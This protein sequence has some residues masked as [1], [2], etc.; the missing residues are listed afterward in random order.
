MCEEKKENGLQEL[1]ARIEYLETSV[2]SR[3]GMGVA[4]VG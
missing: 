1:R 3:R 2:G 4:Q